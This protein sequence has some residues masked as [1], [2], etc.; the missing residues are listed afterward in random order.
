MGS[1][2]VRQKVAD[3]DTQ[4]LY[5]FNIRKNDFFSYC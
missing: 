4:R 3:F 2:I 1:F 5:V